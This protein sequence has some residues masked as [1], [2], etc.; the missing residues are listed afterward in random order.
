MN[1]IQ[2]WRSTGMPRKRERRSFSRIAIMVRPN[3]ER[4]MNSIAPTTRGEAE[5]DK[6]IETVG[7]GQDVDFEQAQINRLAREA[8]QSI[9]P[10]GQR[11]PLKRNVI[12]DLAERDCHHGE[13]DAPTPHDQLTENPATE[14]AE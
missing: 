7:V 13:V 5:Q 11:A 10:T 1:A 8:P 12:E 9:V 2:M 4:R 14:A 3:G 6:V